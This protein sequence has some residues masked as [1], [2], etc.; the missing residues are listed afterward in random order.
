MPQAMR[1]DFV[2]DVVCPWCVIGWKALEQALA[3][4]ADVVTPDVR[5]QPFELNPAM[6]PE[7]QNVAEHIAQKY[8]STPEQSRGTRDLIHS[9]AAGLGFAINSSSE[10]RIWNTFD[11]HRL[12]HWAAEQGRQPQLKLA[13]FEAYFTRQLAVS[14]ADVLVAACESAGLDAAEARAVL[15]E[16]RYIDEV[17]ADE[18]FWRE[19]GISAVPAVIINQKYLI[20]GGQPVEAFEKAIRSIA[21]EG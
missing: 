11:A 13:L 21:A 8:G 18:R 6:P 20:S 15:A 19:Q 5:F 10:S 14:D 9:T 12:L 2:S 16:G 3:N 7:G 1:I 17:R 4:A